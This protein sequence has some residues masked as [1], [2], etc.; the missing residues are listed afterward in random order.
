M[1][2]CHSFLS[3]SFF[4]YFFSHANHSFKSD[5]FFHH[6][7]NSNSS[8]AVLF[9]IES[10]FSIMLCRPTLSTRSNSYASFKLNT[11]IHSLFTLFKSNSFCLSESTIPYCFFPSPTNFRPVKSRKCFLVFLLL[12]SGDIQLNP[13][14]ASFIN[15]N[16]TLPLDVYEPFS[17]PSYAKLRVATLNARSMSNKSAVICDHIIENKLDVLCISETW[18]NGDE[19]TSSLLSSFL[20]SDYCLSQCYGRPHVVEALLSLII[21]PSI[22]L[23]FQ[24]RRFPHVNVLAL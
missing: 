3:L 12:F 14:P 11:V 22:I 15:I 23:L 4:Y 1:P 20:P 24:F 6:V 10:W 16:A 21:I 5:H 17:S 9:N 8:S 2:I 18:I 7:F 19:M 13:G